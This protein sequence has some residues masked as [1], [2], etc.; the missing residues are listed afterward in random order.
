MTMSLYRVI[1]YSLASYITNGTLEQHRV[2]L[3][4]TE[5]Y[6]RARNSSGRSNITKIVYSSIGRRFKGT[7]KSLVRKRE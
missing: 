3:I 4:Y 7:I 5:M 2:A 6:Y 1:V